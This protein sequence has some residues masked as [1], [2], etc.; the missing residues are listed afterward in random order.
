MKNIDQWEN[1]K[2]VKNSEG[3]YEINLDEVNPRSAYIG[4]LII[5]EYQK[6]IEKY[7]KGRLLDCGCG[8]VPYYMIYKNLIDDSFCIDWENTL[9][10]N[11]Y[12]DMV[13]DLNQ[14][15][16]IESNSFDTV[17]LTDVLEHIANPLS[18]IE[19]LARVLLPD[20]HLIVTVP[21][22]Y[23]VHEAPHDY[24]RYTEHALQRFCEQAKLEILE[25]EPYGGYPDVFFDIVNKYL[26]RNKHIAKMYLWIVKRLARLRSVKKNRDKTKH[27]FP[28]GYYLVAKK[29]R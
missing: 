22:F 27:I 25:L 29:E 11:Q 1:T 3:K 4:S 7:S 19:E 28:L 18:L 17:L 15:L 13:V 6:I 9:H 2:F 12:L 14:K 10:K 21:F 16:P 24:Y 23:W 26:G 20:G 5:Q 8:H